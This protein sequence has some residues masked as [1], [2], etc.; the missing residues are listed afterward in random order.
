MSDGNQRTGETDAQ[1]PLEQFDLTLG[2]D[3]DIEPEDINELASGLEQ[4]EAFD[5]DAE[6]GEMLA[7]YAAA[8]KRLSDAAEDARKDVFEDELDDRVSDGERVGPLTKQ[9]GRNTWV[10]DTEAAFAAVADEGADP[11][12]VA[13]VSISD[14]RDVLGADAD[15]YIGESEYT[16]FRR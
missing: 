16:Y 13:K 4:A 10:D 15:Q 6:D 2:M 1:S 8:L 5:A 9:S 7:E 14:L 3:F 11:M 12:D